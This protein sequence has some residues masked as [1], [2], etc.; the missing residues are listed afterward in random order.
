MAKCLLL[1]EKGHAHE[2][3]V[4]FGFLNKDTLSS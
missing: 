4:E 3:M 1:P 2:I